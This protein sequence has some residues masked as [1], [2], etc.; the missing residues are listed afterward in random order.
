[1]RKETIGKIQLAFGIIILIAGIYLFIFN[2]NLRY[3]Q[4]LNIKDKLPNSD[5]EDLVN[6]YVSAWNSFQA[7][8]SF[9]NASNETK[10]IMKVD[11]ANT[12]FTSMESYYSQIT[13]LIYFGVIISLIGIVAILQ[14]LFN[15]KKEIQP[16]I[17][18]VNKVKTLKKNL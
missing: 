9:K 15:L 5:K 1:M 11:F 17:Q 4:A 12:L 14:G 10:T 16:G 6:Q 13:I 2:Y 7:S 18:T 8:E 3:G